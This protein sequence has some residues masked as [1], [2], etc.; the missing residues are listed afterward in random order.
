MKLQI[1][2]VNLLLPTMRKI[3]IPDGG[4]GYGEYIALHI[5]ADGLIRITGMCEHRWKELCDEMYQKFL[6]KAEANAIGHEHN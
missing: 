6:P 5:V 4:A 1:K 2:V 3:T